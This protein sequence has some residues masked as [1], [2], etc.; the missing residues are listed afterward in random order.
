[1][2]VTAIPK[3]LAVWLAVAVTAGMIAA[4]V[5]ARRFRR[6]DRLLAQHRAWLDA[7]DM[8]RKD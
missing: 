1:M 7:H 5:F 4:P 2:I 8:P 6:N 3:I